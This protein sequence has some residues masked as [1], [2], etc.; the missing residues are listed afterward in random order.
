MQNPDVPLEL[1]PL[2]LFLAYNDLGVYPA[3]I[4]DANGNR[5]ERDG[6]G[7]GWNAH[8]DKLADNWCAIEDVLTNLDR[9]LYLNLYPILANELMFI[10]VDPKEQKHKFWL[11]MND[12]FA[13][14]CSDGEDVDTDELP[15][16]CDMYERFGYHGLIAF[17][18]KKR[19][20]S[21]IGPHKTEKYKEAVEY[22]K[23]L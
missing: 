20:K 7:D 15:L 12:T 8:G 2:A 23:T 22:L 16:V 18:A 17:A 9:N 4:I 21:P 14:A 19:G 13:Y 1:G 10:R 11:L 3:A 6:Y 5:T